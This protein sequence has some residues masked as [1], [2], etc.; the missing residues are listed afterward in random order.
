MLIRSLRIK[1]I[2]WDS[3]NFV[4]PLV[5]ERDS[6]YVDQTPSPTRRIARCGTARPADEIE[7]V[8]FSSIFFKLEKP[9]VWK[10][11][12]PALRGSHHQKAAGLGKAPSPGLRGPLTDEKNLARGDESVLP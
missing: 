11:A 12:S 8:P 7:A 6:G 5:L 9:Q 4:S 2:K 10:S 3:L 1:W